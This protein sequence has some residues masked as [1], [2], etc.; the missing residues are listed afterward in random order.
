MKKISLKKLQ[1]SFAVAFGGLIISL[2][3]LVNGLQ[4]IGMVFF[5]VALLGVVML[6]QAGQCPYCHDA[7]SAKWVNPLGTDKEIFCT[8]CGK[9]MEFEDDGIIRMRYKKDEK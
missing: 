3:L 9:K 2:I 7:R 5:I 8:R 6:L 4:Q 1:I